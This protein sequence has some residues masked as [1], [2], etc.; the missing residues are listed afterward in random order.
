MRYVVTSEQFDHFHQM[1]F[2]DFEAFFRKSDIDLLTQLLD[3][4]LEKVPTGRDLQ[5]EDPTLTK[6]LKSS[7]F[8]QIATQLFRKNRLRIGLT[9]YSTCF[10]GTA[11][12]KEIS[13]LSETLGGCLIHL[14]SGG[15]T[16]Y[17]ERFPIDFSSFEKPSL[18]ILI[19]SDKA[20]YQYAEKDPHT[21]LLK[22]LGYAFGDRITN[23]THPL[24]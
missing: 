21:H 14:K 7:K 10:E 17:D 19:S 9:Q 11:S 23:D 4:A 20:R 15:V 2:I 12:I 1:G 6:A 3:A 18:F 8:R 22:K 16:F 13:P 24:L 5:R